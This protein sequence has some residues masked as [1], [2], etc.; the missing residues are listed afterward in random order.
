MAVAGFN[1]AAITIVRRRPPAIDASPPPSSRSG[2]EVAETSVECR[3]CGYDISRSIVGGACPECGVGVTEFLVT[4]RWSSRV[5]RWTALTV[6]CLLLP[7]SCYYFFWTPTDVVGGFVILAVA[8][9]NIAALTIVRRRAP[10]LRS[11][12][13]ATHPVDTCTGSE[14]PCN[15]ADLHEW[16]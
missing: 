1:I 15:S 10:R 9:L 16:F 2:P 5:L 12:P 11:A 3:A 7:L 4:T 6:N 8:G 14:V 13:V